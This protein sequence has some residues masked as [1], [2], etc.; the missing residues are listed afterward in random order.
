MIDTKKSI[1]P[2]HTIIMPTIVNASLVAEESVADTTVESEDASEPSVSSV[3]LTPEVRDSAPAAV[4][5]SALSQ[6]A[7]SVKGLSSAAKLASGHKG[8]GDNVLPL[9]PPGTMAVLCRSCVTTPCCI[10]NLSASVRV[11]VR[12]IR[13]AAVEGCR[14]AVVY[15]VIGCVLSPIPGGAAGRCQA[16]EGQKDH[17]ESHN[18]PLSESSALD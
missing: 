6:Q 13:T 3:S 1:R 16:K 4:E 14:N 10:Y 17:C 7:L 5:G 2:A 11:S 8:S 9:Y 15:D 18:C 12:L